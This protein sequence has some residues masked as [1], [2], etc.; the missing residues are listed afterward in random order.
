M[1]QSK[2]NKQAIE[3]IRKNKALRIELMEYFDCNEGTLYRLLRNNDS[4]L[5]QIGSL[6]LIQAHNPGIQCHE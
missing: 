1:K 6:A 4:K 3:A 2:L 5:T